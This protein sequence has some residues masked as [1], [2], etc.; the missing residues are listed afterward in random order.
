MTSQPDRLSKMTS[1]PSTAKSIKLPDVL[2]L[3]LA[4]IMERR[5]VY[6]EIGPDTH[7]TEQEIC[8]EFH[9]SRSPV[10]EA[11]RH[12]EAR[13]LVVRHSRRGIRV[14]PMTLDHLDEIYFCRIPLEGLAAGYAAQQAT[15]EDLR[16]MEQKLEI[17]SKLV[18]KD[19]LTVFF[20]Q[21]VAFINRMH[22]ATGNKLLADLLSIIEKQALRYRFFAHARE[23]EMR[24]LSCRGYRNIYEAIRSRKSAA[25]KRAAI[26]VMKKGR[27]MIATALQE[28]TSPAGPVKHRA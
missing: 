26:E 8:D 15:E 24:Q 18:L 14:T 4:N 5:I 28:E 11:F 23:P 20:D 19:E 12:L 16:F 6:L 13:G 22:A 3:E 27:L 2:G 1:T 10:R 17:M 9:V 21:N 25:A 7:L